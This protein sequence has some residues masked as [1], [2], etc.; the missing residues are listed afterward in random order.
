MKVFYDMTLTI[1]VVFA[2]D[3]EADFQSAMLTSSSIIVDLDPNT[4]RSE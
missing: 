2:V 4:I 3:R 1:G